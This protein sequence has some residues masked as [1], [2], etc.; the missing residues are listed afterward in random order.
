[1]E[2]IIDNEV[3]TAQIP[4]VL[5]RIRYESQK[6]LFSTIKNHHSY[7]STNCPFHVGGQEKHPSCSIYAETDGKLTWGYCHCFTCGYKASLPQMV[8]DVFEKDLLFGETWLVNR[9]G[10][11]ITDSFKIN[12]E[13]PCKY[14]TN[15]LQFVDFNTK[16]HAPEL[17]AYRYY[18]PYLWE[19]K[20]TKATVDKF[21]IGYDSVRNAITFPIWD[22]HN[23]LIG[24][25]ERCVDYK[26]FFIPPDMNKCVYLL[27]FAKHENA[28]TIIV[29]ESQIDALL[30]WQYGF[31][32]VALL[33]TGSEEQYKILNKCGI[34]CYILMF[35]G[36]DAGRNGAKKF[37][38]NVRNAFTIEVKLPEHKDI[39]DLTEQEFT[40]LVNKTITNSLQNIH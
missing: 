1:M 8:A 39:S 9:Y 36:D 24:I 12:D 28:K 14:S 35:D 18:H 37:T 13:I 21:I 5:N 17:N 31:P 15:S 40:L 4:D 19:R 33:G 25:T 29:C 26:K 23:N 30:C 34:S 7:Y 32:A 3:I 38:R 2:L 16:I 20:L 11:V 6:P 27:N 10:A 22:E